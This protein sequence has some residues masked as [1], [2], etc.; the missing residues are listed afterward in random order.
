M[1]ER[2]QCGGQAEVLAEQRDSTEEVVCAVAHLCRRARAISRFV[3]LWNNPRSRGAAFQLAATERF[4][5]PLPTMDVD[6]CELM[7]DILA[8]EVTQ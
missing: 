6:P 5:W 2:R 3:S 4:P 7:L 1:G 8:Y